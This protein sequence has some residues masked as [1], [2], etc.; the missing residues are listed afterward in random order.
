[1]GIGMLCLLIS[2]IFFYIN[3]YRAWKC[4]SAGEPRTTPGKAVGLLFIPFFNL[5][6]I[7]IAIA[8]LPKD[9]NRIM[10]SYED[11]QKAPKLS[12]K[13]F[14]MFCIGSLVF[15]PLALVVG[16]PLMSQTCKGINFFASRRNPN[17][18]SAFGGFKF[19]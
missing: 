3:I 5:Y 10:A 17:A 2:A 8:A 4:L 18:P 7:F 14:L 13:I 11:L 9:W 19:S 12:G 16:F 15:P 1:M 6:W